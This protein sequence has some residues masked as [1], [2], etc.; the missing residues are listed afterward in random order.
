M[1]LLRTLSGRRELLV[2]LVSREL[3]SRYKGSLLGFL[4]SILTPL[5]MAVI[6]VFFL[7]LLAG[8]GVPT[9]EIIIGV[10]AW[11]FTALSVTGGLTAI[12]GNANLVKKV[13][14]P[15]IILPTA[16]TLAN[17]VNFLLS[18][19]VQFV[20]VAILLRVG[21]RSLS[22]WLVLL[23]LVVVYHTL[24]NLALALLLSAANVY[25]RDTQ[26]LVGVLLSAWFF[27]SPV[28]YNLSFVERFP[29]GY[30]LM[31][32]TYN[33]MALIMP[34]GRHA[35]GP[36]FLTP[37][38]ALVRWS[39]GR[40]VLIFQRR[41]ILCGYARCAIGGTS[42]V[43]R[44]RGWR[45][46]CSACCWILARAHRTLSARW[47]CHPKGAPSRHRPQRLK[48]SPRP[49]RPP[50]PTSGAIQPG[51]HPPSSNNPGSTT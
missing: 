43:H 9:E 24:F 37:A 10:F 27:V 22:G 38:I 12:T 30:R 49:R 6:Y 7:R 26:H 14:F 47:F 50:S 46:T 23:P 3:K 8:R 13:F 28:M 33:P 1:S 32:A 36:A 15:R 48:G 45:R 39:A 42:A 5:L 19:L 51:T 29:T 44:K 35:A 4:W 20:I 31:D 17:L 40:R 16:N 34:P 11:Q 41:E 25:F 18:L 2:N 21:E